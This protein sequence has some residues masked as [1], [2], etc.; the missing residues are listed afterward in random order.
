[1]NLWIDDAKPCPPGWAAARTYEEAY[2]MLQRHDYDIVAFDH[3]LGDGGTGYDLLCA[4]EAGELR[5]PRLAQVISWN[6]VGRARMWAVIRRI[7]D[8]NET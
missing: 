1:M 2:R 3:D 7:W 4:I 6:P 5:R 8:I